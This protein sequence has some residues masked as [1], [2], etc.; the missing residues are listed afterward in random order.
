MYG[1]YADNPIAKGELIGEALGEIVAGE[2]YR[3]DPI[4]QYRSLGTPKPGVRALPAPLNLVLDQRGFGNETRFARNS[5][6]PNAVLRPIIFGKKGGGNAASAD[7]PALFFGLFASREIRGREEIS[8]AWDWDDEHIVHALQPILAAHLKSPSTNVPG[9]A[10]YLQPRF[11]GVLMHLSSVFYTCAC[12]AKKDCALAQMARVAESK[13]LLGL[14]DRSSGGGSRSSRRQKR[15]DLGMLVG[16]IRGWRDDE[17]RRAALASEAIN[18]VLAERA[19]AAAIKPADLFEPATFLPDDDLEYDEDGAPV[20]VSQEDIEMIGALSD[21][22]DAGNVSD[23][24]T[25]TEPMSHFSSDSES[26]ESV[27]ADP[28]TPQRSP[29][30]SPPPLMRTPPVSK[31]RSGVRRRPNN[32]VESESPPT[33][34]LSEPLPPPLAV[35]PPPPQHRFAEPESPLSDA[36]DSSPVMAE[37]PLAPRSPSALQ[38]GPTPEP[39]DVEMSAPVATDDVKDSAAP[40]LPAV[41]NSPPSPPTPPKAPTPPPREP[42]PPPP[43]PPT[44]PPVKRMSLKDWAKRKKEAPMPGPEAVVVP[45]VS[46]ADKASRSVRVDSILLRQTC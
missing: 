1:L 28:R 27:T 44:P 26:D 21:E 33:T 45:I 43:K 11:A 36:P 4:N 6:H 37:A 41:V 2:R 31:V 8:V 24:S 29:S 32:R 30:L 18:R 13:P 14:A 3:N 25:L 22:E 16:A 42:T 34:P 9:L 17:K 15:P 40:S 39:A 38:M 7:E 46:P 10:T 19:A 12:S 5:C 35:T 23:A 20:Y